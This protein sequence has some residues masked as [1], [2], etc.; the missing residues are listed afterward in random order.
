MSSPAGVGARE[1]VERLR[2]VFLHDSG[3]RLQA[4]EIND[5][6]VPGLTA[7][8]YSLDAGRA[9]ASQT[10][11]EKTLAAARR[12]MNDLLDPL[13]GQDLQPGDL[14]RSQASTLDEQPASSR[15]VAPATGRRRCTSPRR[16]SPTWC[17]STSRCPGWTG[18]GPAPDP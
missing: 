7:A 14:V 9:D 12:M 1:A 17:S 11:L 15:E 18:S 5:S 8:V 13:D 10:Y 16:I 2:A 4:L 3:P 6:I